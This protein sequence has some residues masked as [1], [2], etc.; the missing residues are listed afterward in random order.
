M[1]FWVIRN[2]FEKNSQILV[3]NQDVFKIT[4]NPSDFRAPQEVTNGWYIESNIDS[5]SKFNSLKRL[6]TLF[7]MEDELLIKYASVTENESET[8]E[9]PY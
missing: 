1:Y 8:E 9:A 7:E 5:N 4:R 6:L 3:E 2:L